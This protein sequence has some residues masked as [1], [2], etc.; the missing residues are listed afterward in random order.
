[1]SACGLPPQ[2]VD[3]ATNRRSSPRNPAPCGRDPLAP[4]CLGNHVCLARSPGPIRNIRM[5]PASRRHGHPPSI[6]GPRSFPN[7]CAFA[8]E[9]YQF[10]LTKPFGGYFSLASF[11]AANLNAF[12]PAAFFCDFSALAS[13]SLMSFL[14]VFLGGLRSLNSSRSPRSIAAIILSSALFGRVDPDPI[15][16]LSLVHVAY[17]V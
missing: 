7:F 2:P 5:S 14:S 12:N 3:V 10:G 6:L 13:F 15:T 1:M 8:T 11:S 17:Q 16:L 9:A 4:A